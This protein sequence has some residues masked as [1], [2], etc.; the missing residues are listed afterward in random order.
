MASA[1]TRAST[2]DTGK[3][4]QRVHT[5]PLILEPFRKFWRKGIAC[6][7]CASPDGL[8]EA[9]MKFGP[10]YEVKCG[11]S[12]PHPP[13]TFGNPPW[14]ELKKWLP[15]FAEQPDEQVLLI[16]VRA[17]RSYWRDFVWGGGCDAIIWLN[18]FAFV[19]HK[20]EFPG[21]VALTY[22]GRR[23]GAFGVC[24]G[25]LGRVEYIDREAPCT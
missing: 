21:D 13:R 23:Q 11:R 22:K 14:G 25:H 15:H 12:V 17:R 9:S 24:F 10:D 8:V 3:K 5:P 1:L 16:P 20:Y 18:P 2:G 4:P 19:G 7:P 6:D